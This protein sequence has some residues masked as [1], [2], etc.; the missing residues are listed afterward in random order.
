MDDF[1]AILSLTGIFGLCLLG[2]YHNRFEDNW[3]QHIGFGCMGTSSVFLAFNIWKSIW[4]ISPGFG[5]LFVMGVLSFGIGTAVK[6]WRHRKTENKQTL[7][8]PQRT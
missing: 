4:P 3:L 8:S 7:R 6:V 1:I 5:L 2:I